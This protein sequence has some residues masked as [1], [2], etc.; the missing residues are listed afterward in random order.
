L[1]EEAQPQKHYVPAIKVQQWLDGWGQISFDP[2]EYR[3]R[4]KPYFYL[5]SLPARE[6]RSLSGIARRTTSGITPR[7]ADLGIQRQHEPERSA[8]IKQFVEFG[9]PW[10]TLS[11]SKRESL[12]YHD[13]RKPG[14]LPTA[15]VINVLEEADK[16][17]SGPVNPNDLITIEDTPAGSKIALPYSTWTADWRPT[18]T[19]PFEVIDGQHRLWAFEGGETDFDLPVVAFHGLDISWQAYLFW[20]INIKPKRINPSLAFDLYPLLRTEDWLDRAE[21]HEI[22]RDT[23]SQELTEALWSHSDSPWHNKINML[24]ERGNVL[25]IGF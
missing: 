6:L 9:F 19:P 24:G 10:S 16:R 23:R 4:P 18:G 1:S 12:E 21:G 3:R 22:Y 14:W 13:L 7:A 17:P 20:T 8:E 2:K 5:F 25:A 11:Q 15:I